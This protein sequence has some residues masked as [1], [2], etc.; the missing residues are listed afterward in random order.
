MS[1]WKPVRDRIVQASHETRNEIIGFLLGRL[2]RDTIIIDDTIT[3]EFSS[4]P[5][6]VA[7]LPSALG[8]IADELVSGRVK[9]NI[10]GWYHSHTEG[11]VFFS[12][13]DIET[14]RALQQFSSLV[15]GVVIDADTGEVGYFRIDPQS[16]KPFRIPEERVSVRTEPF[17]AI[18]SEPA[19]NVSP[20]PTPTIE[21]RPERVLP[22]QPRIQPKQRLSTT[23]IAI[24]IIALVASAGL[25]GALLFYSANP[26]TSLSIAQ[27]PVTSGIVGTPIQITANVTGSVRNVTLYVAAASENF[28]SV[29]MTVLKGNLYGFTIPGVEVTGNLAYYIVAT[30]QAGNQKQTSQD[31]ILISDFALS[32][33]TPAFTVYRNKTQTTSGELDLFTTNGFSQQVSLS[34]NGAPSG[35]TIIFS[36]NPVPVSLTKV[37]MSLAASQTTPNGTYQIV[38]SGTYSPTGAQPVT[39]RVTIPVTVADFN[40]QISPSLVQMSAGK[41]GTYTLLITLQRGFVDPVAVT[42]EGLPPGATY[43]LTTTGN[44]VGGLGTGP[45]TVTMTLQIMTT[46][47]K[48][49]SYTLTINAS[50]GG[51]THSQRVQ[52]IVR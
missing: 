28:S 14:Q 40:L 38:V 24:V 48:S 31:R 34:A 6:H 45:G 2:Q 47:V 11:G 44:I 25:I 22:P 36:P 43:S 30:D 10:V 41:S 15:T 35:L 32:A 16:R 42:V 37:T 19:T 33:V 46:A 23:I 13:T 8:K 17:E 5:H 52:L 49:G 26:S 18:T 29:Q 3:G 7:L 39:R 50:G 9:G 1:I 12:E 21:V 27:N 51:I 20:R 4:E